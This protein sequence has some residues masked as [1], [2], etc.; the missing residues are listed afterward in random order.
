MPHQMIQSATHSRWKQ[1]FPA[2]ILVFVLIFISVD[3]LTHFPCLGCAEIFH[4][5]SRENTT[6]EHELQL[7]NRKYRA[8]LQEEKRNSTRAFLLNRTQNK[9]NR[10]ISKIPFSISHPNPGFSSSRDSKTILRI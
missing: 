3:F 10:S 7:L 2:I 1:K 5:H 8:V 4:E 6:N 9:Q